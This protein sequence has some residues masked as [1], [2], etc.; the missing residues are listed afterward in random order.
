MTNNNDNAERDE[1]HTIR[2]GSEFWGEKLPDV[3]EAVNADTGETQ[4]L[5]VDPGGDD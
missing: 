4:L 2:A 5:K 3:I 1:P